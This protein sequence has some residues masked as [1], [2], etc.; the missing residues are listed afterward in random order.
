MTNLITRL[1]EGEGADWALLSV[2]LNNHD[3]FLQAVTNPRLRGWFVGKTF[4]ATN[5]K[6]DRQAVEELLDACVALI[7]V[8]EASH[9]D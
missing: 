2:I 7:T 3:K 1:T 9:G 5:G 8:K 6:G 4:Q